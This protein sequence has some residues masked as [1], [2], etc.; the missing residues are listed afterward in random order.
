MRFFMLAF[1]LL[2]L[3]FAG[4]AGAACA[5][6]MGGCVEAP[7]AGHGAAA[8]ASAC[9]PGKAGDVGHKLHKCAHDACCGTMLAQISEFSAFPAPLPLR[10]AALPAAI[11]PL[12]GSGWGPL[13]DPPRA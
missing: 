13:L 4:P 12:T 1:C 5:A 8:G 7:V 11:T 2:S 9:D 3:V 10:V 6:D